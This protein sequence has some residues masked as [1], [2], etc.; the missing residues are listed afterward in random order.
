MPFINSV[1]GSF[2]AQSGLFR[3][4]LRLVGSTGGTIATAGG[5]TTHT[6][7]TDTR[8]GGTFNFQA[9][10]SGTVE[11]LLVAGGGG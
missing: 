6:F 10:G 11:V 1:R 7:V 3:S 9:S 4:S 8:V 2:G 5:L